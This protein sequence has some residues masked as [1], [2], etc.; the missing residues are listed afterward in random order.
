MIFLE[1][2]KHNILQ[3]SCSSGRVTNGIEALK[4]RFTISKKLDEFSKFKRQHNKTYL[5][6]YVCSESS[7]E[8]SHNTKQNSNR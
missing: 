7:D 1:L 4:G 2:T 5:T 6:S 3:P 8:W